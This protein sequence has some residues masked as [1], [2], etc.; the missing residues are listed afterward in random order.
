LDPNACLKRFLDALEDADASEAYE[1]HLDLSVW[2]DRG[3]FE[4][5]DRE[6]LAKFRAWVRLPKY[7]SVGCYPLLYARPAGGEFVCAVCASSEGIEQWAGDVHWE[8]EPYDCDECG[9][10]VESAYGSAEIADE[11]TDE[12]LADSVE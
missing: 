1:A 8:G 9:D 12:D 6:G 4:P 2:L 3:G 11:R 5:A 10:P 7:T